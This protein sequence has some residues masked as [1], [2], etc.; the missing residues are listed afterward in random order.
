[1]AIEMKACRCINIKQCRV[2]GLAQAIEIHDI[3]QKNGVG[4][5]AEE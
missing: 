1:M 5:G 3:C 4:S 2:G